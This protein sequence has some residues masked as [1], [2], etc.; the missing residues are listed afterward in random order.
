MIR[1]AVLFGGTSSEHEISC[2]SALGVA[3]ALDREAYEVVLIGADRT[4]RWHRVRT[5]EELRHPSAEGTRLPE[6]ADIDVVFPVLHG[7]NGED[8]TVQG[9]LELAG[10]PYVGCGVLA[11]AL[12]MDKARTAIV[13]EAAGVRTV[14]GV[15]LTA[16]D[17]AHQATAHLPYPRFVK[18]NRAGSSIGVRK[19]ESPR[20]LAEAVAHALAHDD[21]ILV[22]PA[23]A[24]DEIDVGVLQLPGGTPTTGALLRVRP[25]ADAAFFDFDAK[26]TQGG[27]AF[28]VPARVPAAVEATLR[29]LAVRAFAALGCDGLAR[30]DFFVT[31]DGDVCV[32]EVNTMPGMSTLSQFPT[33]FRAAG[34]DL[35]T[36]L[37]ILISRA[38]VAR[39]PVGAR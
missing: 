11:S 17:D 39:E 3:S 15:A 5:I 12:A 35:P 1:V 31:H 23:M 4:G 20:E 25:A 24:G 13:L 33:M 7:L 28:E 16:R 21:T 32:N 36:V 14:P 38:L 27:A 6:L 34:T 2:A 9:L 26:Y 19:V 37:D 22:Q 8:G 29:R 30:V 18:P 10:V